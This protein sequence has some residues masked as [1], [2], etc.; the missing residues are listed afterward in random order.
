MTIA[1]AVIGAGSTML[2]AVASSNQMK[3]QASAAQQQANIEGEWSKR[4]ALE[5]AASAQSEASN[6]TREAKFLQSKLTAAAGGSGSRADDPTVM[7]LW[8]DIGQEG[9]YGS[10]Q[11]LAAG[12][13]AMAGATYQRDLNSWSANTNARIAKSGAQ[14]TLIGGALGSASQIAGGF[15]Q[16]RMAGRYGQPQSNSYRYG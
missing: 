13:Q 14:A 2:G 8:G 9:R 15:A 11:A 6:R 7:A 16:S 5:D 12:N 10:Q 3:A 4:K 1:S